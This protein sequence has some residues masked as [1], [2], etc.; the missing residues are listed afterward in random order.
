VGNLY[1]SERQAEVHPLC[2]VTPRDSG[3]VSKIMKTLTGLRA[4]F[5]VK[6][7]G[8]TAFPGGS[9]SDDGVTID[10][11]YMNA[12]SVSAD[13]ATVSVGPGN[14]WVNISSVLD[15]LGIVDAILISS[16]AIVTNPIRSKASLWLE[17]G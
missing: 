14:R 15:P 11:K 13:R 12:I 8:H 1:W 6:G 10:L 5:S 9:N 3:D 2:F 7:G 4:S 16:Y 17:V